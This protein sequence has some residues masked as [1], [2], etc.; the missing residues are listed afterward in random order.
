VVIWTL[1][2]RGWLLL[3][4]HSMGADAP[5]IE[6]C[7]RQADRLVRSRLLCWPCPSL[8]CGEGQGQHALRARPSLGVR[9]FSQICRQI[10]G[11]ENVAIHCPAAMS[12][13]WNI[14]HGFNCAP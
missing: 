2:S 7:R 14:S 1:C 5:G 9:H 6:A 11:R 10:I 8:F 12:F 3:F 13:G 4:E